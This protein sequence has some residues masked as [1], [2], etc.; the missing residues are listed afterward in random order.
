M[1]Y[2]FG[3][4]H[5]RLFWCMSPPAFFFT[6]SLMACLSLILP[7]RGSRNCRAL[8]APV[9]GIEGMP[10]FFFRHPK[11]AKILKGIEKPVRF[12]L[13]FH[14]F[15]NWFK[16]PMGR[17]TNLTKW[18]E[19][20]GHLVLL[21]FK[22]LAT[23]GRWVSNLFQIICTSQTEIETSNSFETNV[24]NVYDLLNDGLYGKWAKSPENA[25][26]IF[27][28]PN[29]HFQW[30]C[31]P[32]DPRIRSCDVQTFGPGWWCLAS[33][34]RIRLSASWCTVFFLFF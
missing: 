7:L 32:R 15:D 25:N 3:G 9:I 24:R 1:Q 5:P 26:A 31:D 29:T 10:F 23:G 22:F 14:F 6:T 2:F 17:L 30:F 18:H 13:W 27:T 8:L 11:N 16:T 4:K 12:A 20:F 34:Q 28:P 33:G 19:L 21:G